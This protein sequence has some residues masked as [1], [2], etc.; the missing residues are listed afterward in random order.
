MKTKRAT[1]PRETINKGLKDTFELKQKRSNQTSKTSIQRQRFYYV[2]CHHKPPINGY[3]ISIEKILEYVSASIPRVYNHILN[4]TVSRHKFKS[5][6]K[7]HP[8]MMSFVG[9][10]GTREYA[11]SF[12]QLPHS[13]TILALHS[14]TEARFLDLVDPPIC[15]TNLSQLVDPFQGA[16]PKP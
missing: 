15:G 12:V 4:K 10:S 6:R 9:F 7:L 2:N 5:R 11:S 3:I 14:D 13:H 16:T 8:F 1:A